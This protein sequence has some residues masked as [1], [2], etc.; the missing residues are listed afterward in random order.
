MKRIDLGNLANVAEAIAAIGVIISLIYLGVQIQQNTNAIRAS[1]YQSVAD[2]ITDFQLGLAQNSD[3]VRIYLTGLEG[4]GQLT[5]IER[6]RF[7]YYM[8]MLFT[9]FDTAVEL[10][11]RGMIDDK[12]MTPYSRFIIYHLEY[13]GVIEYWQESQIYFSDAMRTYVKH[14]KESS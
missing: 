14:L 11:N 8:G 12:A 10:Y 13:P 7:E 3:L 1:S 6:T 5:P 9:R 4:L 2:D